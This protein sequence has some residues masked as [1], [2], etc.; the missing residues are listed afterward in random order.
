M[1]KAAR[2]FVGRFDFFFYTLF[3][4]FLGVCVSWGVVD[5]KRYEDIDW[6]T[7][8]RSQQSCSNPG[9]KSYNSWLYS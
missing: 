4:L 1:I 6:Y 7:T 3:S 2:S 9:H 5:G 8:S